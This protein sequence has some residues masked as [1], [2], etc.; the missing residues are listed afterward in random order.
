MKTLMSK[1]GILFAASALLLSGCA[2]SGTSSGAQTATASAQGFGGEV[3]VT[4]TVQDNALTQVEIQGSQETETVGGKAMTALQTA[5]LESKSVH[6]DTISGATI[7][8]EAVLN[9]AKQAW[10]TAVGNQTAAAEVKMKPGTYTAAAP[11]FRSAWD[12]EVSVTVDETNL[13][14]ID[15]NPDSADTVG[16]FQSAAEILPQRM[17]EQQ[18]VAVDS[19]CGQLFPATRSKVRLRKRLPKL[20]KLPEPIHRRY[21]RLKRLPQNPLTRKNSIRI[22]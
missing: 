18:S 12:I 4:V 7:T 9:A 5:M 3:S 19:V 16:I 21:P 14:S 11:G 2:K 10:N 15:V 8:S 17:I 20:W 1:T 6:V 22:S 13:I